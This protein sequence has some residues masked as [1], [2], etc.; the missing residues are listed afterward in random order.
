MDQPRCALCV[1]T[2]TDCVYPTKRKPRDG[3]RTTN[4][5]SKQPAQNGTTNGLI[6]LFET[7]QPLMGQDLS[8]GAALPAA[9]WGVESI[10][11]QQ[12][13]CTAG[14]IAS[15]SQNL[16]TA[17][18]NQLLR[19]SMATAVAAEAATSN[20]LLHQLSQ[21]PPGTSPGDCSNDIAAHLVDLFF[22][23]VQPWLP[24]L[25][26][27]RFQSYLHEKL[28]REENALASLD[29]DEVLLLMGMFA[30]SSRFLPGGSLL[31][32][33]SLQWQEAYAAKA[34]TFYK[35]IRDSDSSFTLT[36]LQG[37]IAFAVYSSSCGL[38]ARG[39]ILVGVCVRMAYE[40]GLSELDSADDGSEPQMDWTL[41]EERRR[42]WWLVWELDTF[43]SYVR[44][45][46]YAVNK[47]A[48]SVALPASDEAWFRDEKTL[49]VSIPT[50]DAGSWSDLKNCENQNERAWYLAATELLSQSA[51]CL[52]QH[53]QLNPERLCVLQNNVSCFRL[54]LPSIF[55][56]ESDTPQLQTLPVDRSNWITG[57]H[58]ALS[59]ASYLVSCLALLD[60]QGRPPRD[61]KK[62]SE[63]LQARAFDIA[64]L[65][66]R[67]PMQHV[68]YAHP[69][70][71]LLFLTPHVSFLE[72][73][74]TTSV[75]SSSMEVVKL[76]QSC[77]GEFWNIGTIAER[78]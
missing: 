20:I 58:M 62:Y 50:E 11:G 77:I 67:W 65:V 16:S 6:Q 63:I 12:A 59:T 55:R 4:R 1:R 74:P 9:Q 39:W 3:V 26:K 18:Q 25:H 42:A 61:T 28:R 15:A 17:P 73:S 19:P 36:F 47:R 70:Y 33:P 21:P 68:R 57:T 64:Y 23:H 72:P 71:S 78:E 60:S 10:T 56:R 30:L 76:I 5:A 14:S 22:D 40:L 27:P 66:W 75:T 13:A 32:F 29:S 34:A 53:R 37:T 52:L 48:I 69:F 7:H 45:K 24:M 49:S 43:S 35:Q 51:E 54:A 31:G 46:P 8:P 41:M 38:S 44:R 2:G